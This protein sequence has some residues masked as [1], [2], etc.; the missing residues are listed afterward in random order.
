MKEYQSFPLTSGYQK[1]F[2]GT[3]NIPLSSDNCQLM[4]KVMEETTKGNLILSP[5][6][7]QCQI[8]RR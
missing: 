4:E 8:K 6:Q 5:Q 2:S 3:T 1:D 7:L